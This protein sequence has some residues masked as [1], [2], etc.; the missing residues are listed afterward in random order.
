MLLTKIKNEVISDVKTYISGCIEFP[1]IGL[2]QLILFASAG[3][4]F[5]Y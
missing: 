3:F 1:S 2:T 4:Y 5:F